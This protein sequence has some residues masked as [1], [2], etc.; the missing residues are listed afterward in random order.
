VV[1]TDGLIG[2]EAK[3]LLKNLSSLSAEKWEKPYS[4][5]CGYVNAQMSIAVIQC[6]SHTPLLERLSYSYQPDERS[7]SPS[8]K[9]R[10]DSVSFDI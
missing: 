10:Q 4:V 7:S 9:T 3:T 2:K 8:G 1:S 5:V 6:P